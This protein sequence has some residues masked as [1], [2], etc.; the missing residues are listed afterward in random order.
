[1]LQQLRLLLKKHQR[2]DNSEESLQ[3]RECFRATE[4]KSRLARQRRRNQGFAEHSINTHFKPYSCP[5]TSER[6]SDLK[7]DC[8]FD[9]VLDIC[10][11]GVF[12]LS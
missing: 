8:V 5:V 2:D 10:T 3:G 11:R 7:H 1:M 6:S 4:T 9:L 12:P